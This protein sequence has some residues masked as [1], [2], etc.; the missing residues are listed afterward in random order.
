MGMVEYLVKRVVYTI[1]VL[2]AVLTIVFFLFRVMPAN[3][4]SIMVDSNLPP[5]AQAALKA[6]WGLDKP[7][8]EQYLVYLGNFLE[9]NFGN[10]F[11]Y[12]QPAWNMLKGPLFNTLLL[13]APALAIGSIIGVL[14]GTYAGWRR[15][16]FWERLIILFVSI[17][18][19]IPSFVLGIIALMLFSYGLGLFPLGGM[20]TPG[21]VTA[22][23]DQ[24]FSLDF[25][26]HYFLPLCVTIL[27]FV[28][29]STLLMRTS[30]IEVRGEEFLELIKAKG[31]A[32][33]T[34]IK[35][36]V[37]NSMLPVVTWIFSNVGYAIAGLMFIEVVFN[38][39]GIGRELVSSVSR[40]DY[41][42]AQA[43]FFVIAVI[44]VLANLVND[45]LYGYLDPRVV[46]D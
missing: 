41:P 22:G 3:P 11:Y 25:L 37:R 30:I 28:P 23:L 9:L 35:H 45:L 15:G 34:I 12:G 46:Y 1:I 36:A 17:I 26:G 31:M 29:E 38:W 7:L 2:W 19:G 18:R 14:L 4:V 33:R 40:L 5:A 44:I 21:T 13:A 8:G 27:L 20:S 39:P 32:E 42:M 43:A 16:S 24:Y 6:Q 10:S